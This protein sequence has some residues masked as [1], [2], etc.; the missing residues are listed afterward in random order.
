MTGIRSYILENE[1]KITILSNKINI[2][3]YEDI[4]SFESQKVIIKYTKGEI[5]IKGNN[6]VVSKL[7]SDEVLITGVIKNIEFR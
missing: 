5:V 2:L 1:F 3:N 4:V 7:I 6:L